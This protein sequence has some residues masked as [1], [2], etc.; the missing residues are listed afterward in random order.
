MVKCYVPVAALTLIPGFRIG[1]Y[2]ACDR[3][4][5]REHNFGE[6]FPKTGRDIVAH[7]VD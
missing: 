5:M 2:T 1:R 3:P 6:R 7:T 4:D